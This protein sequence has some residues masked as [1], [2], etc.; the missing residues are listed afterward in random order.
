MQSNKLFFESLHNPLSLSGSVKPV[1]ALPGPWNGKR[2]VTV[3][4]VQDIHKELVGSGLFVG[5]WFVGLLSPKPCD[6]HCV[7]R[8]GA[9]R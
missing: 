9:G 6:R 1:H 2:A 4:S 3:N 7:G 5:S 8:V